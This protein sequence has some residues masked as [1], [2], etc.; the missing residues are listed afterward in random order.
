V[1]HLDLGDEPAGLAKARDGGMK[2]AAARLPATT[3]SERE[4][5]TRAL[6]GY[7]KPTRKALHRRQRGK[8]AWCERPVGATGEPVEHVRPKLGADARDKSRDPDHYWWLTWTWTNLVYACNGC[9]NQAN[10]GNRYWL[11]P[12]TSRLAAPAVPVALP[13]DDKHFD[14]STELPL[15]VHPR[16]EDPS[17]YLRWIPVDQRQPK[18]RWRWTLRGRDAGDRGAATIEMLGLS[19]L[20][21]SV[22]AHLRATVLFQDWH[23]REHLK[24]GRLAE[25]RDTWLKMI[26]THIDDPEQVFRAAAWCAVISLWP[27]GERARFGF[28]EPQVPVVRWRPSAST[29]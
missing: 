3:G 12:G 17:Q 1:I 16:L 24:A 13:L 4:A 2:K 19:E 28:V 5:L 14:V 9:N 29:P 6:T 8:C 11:T 10:K 21:D 20:E 15:L 22:N 23:L 25:A 26:A 27:G 18:S 7:A